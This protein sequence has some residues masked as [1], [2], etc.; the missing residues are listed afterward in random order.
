[1]AP[2][3]A[4]KIGSVVKII[5]ASVAGTRAKATLSTQRAAAVVI[6][7]VYKIPPSASL[8]FTMGPK[9][10]TWKDICDNAS[11]MPPS[12]MCSRGCSSNIPRDARATT[13]SLIHDTGRAASGFSP[14]IRSS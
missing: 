5:L 1:M 9:L 14:M 10:G 7:P 11:E 12:L 4:A 2:A 6:M 3:T 8:E 13:I